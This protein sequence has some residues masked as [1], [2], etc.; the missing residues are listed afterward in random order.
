M[1]LQPLKSNTV[2]MGSGLACVLFILLSSVTSKVG[3]Y[4]QPLFYIGFYLYYFLSLQRHNYVFAIFLISAYIGEAF[5]ITDVH[6]YFVLVI[7]MFVIAAAAML[8]TFIPMLRLKPRKITK[9]MLVEPSIGILFCIYT[10]VYLMTM[11]YNLIPNKFLFVAGAI[12]LLFYT[13]VCFLI[14]LRNRHPS[15]VYLYLIGGGLLIESILSF[16]YTY[17]MP[18]PVIAVGTKIAI[19]VHKAC[20][21]LYFVSI[22]HVRTDMSYDEY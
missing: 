4:I 14:P 8:Y 3:Y 5:L 22:E 20:V 16:V 19:C 2:L 15:N 1:E 12:L 18:I 11:Y 17:S 6:R 21:T 9:E 7:S 10:V 13:I